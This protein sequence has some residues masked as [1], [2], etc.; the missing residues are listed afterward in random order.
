MKSGW[1][2]QVSS[3]RIWARW[4]EPGE[5]GGQQH[6]FIQVPLSLPP[7]WRQGCSSLQAGRA[8]PT[9]GLT[10]CFRGRREISHSS[11]RLFSNSFSLKYSRA[12]MPY[13]G[14]ACS[15]P[16]LSKYVILRKIY[17][18]IIAIKS[19][20]IIPHIMKREYFPG[21]WKRKYKQKTHFPAH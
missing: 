12:N 5:R 19:G 14:V 8:P 11:N 20:I 13:F 4:G 15:K 3:K 1:S 7:P 16:F 6:L 2:G 17:S 10:S 9:E 21:A 18:G